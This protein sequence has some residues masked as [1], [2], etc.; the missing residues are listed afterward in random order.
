MTLHQLKCFRVVA[1]YQSFTAA[2]K[3]LL[4]S[5]PAL[6]QSIKDLENSLGFQL[7]DRVG[8]KIRLSPAGTTFY[9]H[10]DRLLEI[11]SQASDTSIQKEA[12][13]EDIYFLFG[14]ILPDLLNHVLT[15]TQ[16]IPN[17]NLHIYMISQGEDVKNIEPDFYI[18]KDEAQHYGQSRV[19]LEP[20]ELT[21]LLPNNHPLADEEEISFK[22]LMND[23]L[24]FC[25]KTAMDIYQQCLVSAGSI[26]S[27]IF[28]NDRMMLLETLAHGS[29]A[30]LAPSTDAHEYCRFVD[31]SPHR[32]RD[33]GF[34]KR[35]VYMSWDDR[36]FASATK[37]LLL[38]YILDVYRISPELI[39][40]G[41]AYG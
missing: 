6:S 1:K 15:F 23:R 32:L 10:C 12:V 39:R 11:L 2:S 31:Y 41:K 3:E 20:H 26:K 14:T 9:R 40:Y 27:P 19:M 22:D 37:R 29:Y 5:Q 33:K 4:I 7:F 17:I 28:M 13:P 35:H 16:E 25:S 18:A 38:N 36:I 21:C 24:I 30:A 34:R 8:R